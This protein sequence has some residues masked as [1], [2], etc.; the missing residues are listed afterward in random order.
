MEREKTEKTVR[1]VELVYM[2]LYLAFDGRRSTL[3]EQ[4]A[5]QPLSRT[6]VDD[7]LSCIA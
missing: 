5:C 4:H 3:S 2:I 1:E 6:A 7:D